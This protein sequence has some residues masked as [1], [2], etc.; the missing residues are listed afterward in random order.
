MLPAPVIPTQLQEKYSVYLYGE[1]TA[2]A[3]IAAGSLGAYCPL[4]PQ[5]LSRDQSRIL[6]GRAA[7]GGRCQ[8][9]Y[10]QTHLHGLHS[11]VAYGAAYRSHIGLLTGRVCPYR[12]YA[13]IIQR[14]E[15]RIQIKAHVPS[16]L[17]FTHS[18]QQ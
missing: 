16:P 12:R 5:H 15:Y 3:V 8:D 7:Q 17:F 6:A 1:Q 2:P 11:L 14:L 10:Q 18:P 13:T 4:P 9:R